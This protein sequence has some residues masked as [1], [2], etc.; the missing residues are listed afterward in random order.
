MCFKLSCPLKGCWFSA[1]LKTPKPCLSSLI[2]L[3][4]PSRLYSWIIKFAWVFKSDCSLEAI[5]EPKGLGL[6]TGFE[7]ASFGL[8]V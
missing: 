2:K 3:V 1:A 7:F 8:G 6:R 4:K 5:S